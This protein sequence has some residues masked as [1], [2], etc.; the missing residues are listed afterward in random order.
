MEN[1]CLSFATPT[2]LSEKSKASVIVHEIAHSRIGNLVINSTFEHILAEQGLHRVH[3]EE[4]PGE[5]EGVADQKLQCYSRLEGFGRMCQLSVP[6]QPS[7][8][9]TIS[10]VPGGAGGGI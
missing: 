5:D 8:F 10:L 4:Y 7:A 1:P 9:S 6:L 2:L 3:R